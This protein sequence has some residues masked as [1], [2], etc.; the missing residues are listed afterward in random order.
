MDD[1]GEGMASLPLALPID[2]LIAIRIKHKN[3]KK[4]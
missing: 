3:K 2:L 4:L 1:W